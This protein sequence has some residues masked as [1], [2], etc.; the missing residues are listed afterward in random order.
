[1][2]MKF[3]RKSCA[4][5]RVGH[6]ECI[7]TPSMAAGLGEVCGTGQG[8]GHGGGQLCRRGA[9]AREDGG[10]AHPCAGRRLFLGAE[11]ERASRGVAGGTDAGG[12]CL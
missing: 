12:S 5:Q 2:T 8:G 10:A 4:H 1:M 9:G 6:A 11:G 7:V 3:V